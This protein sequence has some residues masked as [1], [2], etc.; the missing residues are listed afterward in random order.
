MPGYEFSLGI[1]DL[2]TVIRQSLSERIT[3]NE[4]WFSSRRQP[5][6][7]ACHPWAPKSKDCIYDQGLLL[8]LMEKQV[9]NVW[10]YLRTGEKGDS[11]EE[12][13]VNPD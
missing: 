9:V 2:A 11:A 13:T 6:L 4:S 8:P 5:T 7:S 10:T 1:I 12:G 3:A